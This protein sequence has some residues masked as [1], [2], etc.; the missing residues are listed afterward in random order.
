MIAPH[1]CIHD[2]PTQP[3]FQLSTLVGQAVIGPAID[4]IVGQTVNC[5]SQA[6][7]RE[8][9]TYSYLKDS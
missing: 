2:I 8:P 6:A 1:I 7:N 3:G 4:S 9:Q 5:L